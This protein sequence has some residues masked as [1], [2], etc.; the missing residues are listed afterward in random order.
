[1]WFK[2][3]DTSGRKKVRRLLRA[4]QDLEQYRNGRCLER[5]TIDEVSCVVGILAWYV[6]ACIFL[7]RKGVYQCHIH[8]DVDVGA[9]RNR[10]SWLVHD[11][12][13]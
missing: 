1:V 13:E 11:S 7:G 3:E 9:A 6:R 10:F 8:I 2:T 5:G 4:T 12:V